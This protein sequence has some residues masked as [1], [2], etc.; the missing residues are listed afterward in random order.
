MSTYILFFLF[1]IFIAL[2]TT[3]GKNS[4]II[5]VRKLLL[6]IISVLFI[7]SLIYFS[8][9]AV[10]AAQR[11]ISLWLN[12]VFPSLFP[13]FVASELLNK[14]GF[15]RAVGILL[16]PV[17]RPLFSVP[18]C[19]S[20]AF[21]MGITSG[22]P[23]GA[24]ITSSLMEEKLVNKTEAERLLAF[25]NNS[26]PLFI[27]GAVGV[28]MF[29]SSR[30]GIF[31]LICHIIACITVGML[32]RYH[33]KNNKEK[34]F[35]R[36]ENIFKRFMFE[37]KNARPSGSMSSLFG[38]AI[39]NSISLVLAIGG[40]IIFFS[41]VINLL[42]QTGFIEM[43]ADV[44]AM[45]LSP[46]AVDKKIIASVASGFFEITTG[47]NLVSK[48]AEVPLIYKLTAASGI[49]GWAGISVHFQV[50]SIMNNSGI[51]MKPY[52][53]GKCLQGVLAALYTYTFIRISD[54]FSINLIY[55][56]SPAFSTFYSNPNWSGCFSYSLAYLGIAIGTLLL[57]GLSLSLFQYGKRKRKG[58]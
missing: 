53:L 28:G 18:G 51:S 15:V 48:I 42:L 27:V 20:F 49:I 19:G 44:G 52:L 32:F 37:L 35:H 1:L 26:G 36:N 4:K 43:V 6:P 16:E 7:L 46:L 25:T 31:L 23:V 8:K 45:I 22:Y 3:N 56:T 33:G 2:I 57:T 30:I 38:D 5:Y 41:V 34:L 39:K 10:N 14:S 24:K 12:V 50:A 58:F 40:F 9:T 54:S 13:F 47:T 11:G 17:M 21:A 55:K 29:N